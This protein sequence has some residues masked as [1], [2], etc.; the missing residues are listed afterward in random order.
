MS[1]DTDM[2]NDGEP[3]MFGVPVSDWHDAVIKGARIH[4]ARFE[5]AAEILINQHGFLPEEIAHMRSIFEQGL[6]AKYTFP[7]IKAEDTRDSGLD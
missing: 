3:Y 2:P 4:G 1:F 7:K 6:V 5:A